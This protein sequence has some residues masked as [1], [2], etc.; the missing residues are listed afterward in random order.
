M[1]QKYLRKW[2]G[3]EKGKGNGGRWLVDVVMRSSPPVVGNGW[4]IISP[5]TSWYL[6]WP[7][8]GFGEVGLRVR[9]GIRVW[10]RATIKKG[11]VM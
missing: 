5:C 1:F 2:K 9:I 11:L 7:N 6:K 3:K 4:W 8:L 10:V